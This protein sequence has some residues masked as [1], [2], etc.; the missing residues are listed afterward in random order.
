MV[1]GHERGFA[2][3]KNVGV[4]LLHTQAKRDAEVDDLCDAHP[5]L[6]GMGIGKTQPCWCRETAFE[7][8]GTGKVANYDN[9]YHEGGWYY[10]LNACARFDLAAWRK[11]P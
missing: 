2:F 11:I 4:D 1:A 5:D 6:L 7:V 3:L 9:K 10:W 8:I